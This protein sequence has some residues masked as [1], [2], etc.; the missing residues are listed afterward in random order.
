MKKTK[1]L[2]ARLDSLNITNEETGDS[3][4][5]FAALQERKL[6]AG[7]FGLLLVSMLLTKADMSL[8]FT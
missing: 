4:I 3:Y 1:A 6:P 7:S 2:L 5:A 8:S